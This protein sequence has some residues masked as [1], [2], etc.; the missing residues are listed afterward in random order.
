MTE[1]KIVIQKNIFLV[2]DADKL[3]LVKNGKCVSISKQNSIVK[4][5]QLQSHYERIGTPIHAVV[6]IMESKETN[7]LIAVDSVSLIGTI[8]GNKVY[9][10]ESFIYYPFYTKNVPINNF[11]KDCIKKI[12]NFLQ[13]NT[14][15]FS[16]T[17]DLSLSYFSLAKNNFVK[18]SESN[19]FSH[20]NTKFV[21][22]LNNT[23]QIDNVLLSE[24]VFP[25]INGFI[26]IKNSKSYEK[27]FSY[28]VISRKEHKRSGCR[29]I[30]RGADLNGNT[31]NFAETEQSVIL[32]NTLN[33]E[34]NV[35][36]YLQ[37]RG[38]VPLIWSQLPNLQL[39]PPIVISSSYSENSQAFNR[40]FTSVINSYDRVTIVNLIDK[41]SYQK[42]LGDNYN[43]YYKKF[44]QS[45]VT[46]SNN[47]NLNLSNSNVNNPS[48]SIDYSWFDFHAECKKMKYEN[49]GKL[50]KTNCVSSSLSSHEFSHLT[51]KK[52]L[53]NSNS[54]SNLNE[55]NSLLNNSSY[56]F[57]A[58]NSLKIVARQNG[59]FRTNCIDN[60][61]RTNVVQSVFARQFLHKILYR[62]KLSE[63][64]HGNPF[65]EFV[66]SF[67]N[68]FRICW[69][70]NGD[71]ISKAYSGTNALKRDFTRTGKRT[72]KGNLDD[73]VNT[74]TR[75]YINNFC[76]GYNQ[77]CQDFFLN[78]LNHRKKNFKTHS[79]MFVKLLIFLFLQA[80]IKNMV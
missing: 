46:N 25:I 30:V 54:N 24:F 1:N 66:G 41:K 39:N 42:L 50:L 12:N 57:L 75:F 6:G 13:R 16:D 15:Y 64:P 34:Y 3:I 62:L 56:A 32:Y 29:F 68:T 70:D 77:D 14:L 74:C 55:S 51:F 38:S 22:N 35:Y 23:T 73:G 4:T 27:E 78:S 9:K 2:N 17:Y 7:F 58:S 26:G 48:E 63:M 72:I 65:E 11:D 18:L 8:M 45:L 21:W 47:N 52:E 71:I 80:K 44:K 19:L 60:L 36:S 61:D 40:H 28:A 67:E 59:V 31:A 43:D 49:I 76:D 10:I 20:S 33:S 37:I 53:L 5:E 69:G 79:T